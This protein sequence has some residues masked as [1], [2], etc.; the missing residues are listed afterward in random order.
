MTTV[1]MT[2]SDQQEFT[3][4]KNIIYQSAL[5]KNMIADLDVGTAPIP[6]PNVTGRILSKGLIDL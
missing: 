2:S 5:I 1:K 6:L 3:V 4:E